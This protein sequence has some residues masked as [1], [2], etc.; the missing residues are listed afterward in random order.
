MQRILNIP[1]EGR[2]KI[3]EQCRAYSDFLQTI[4]IW[5]ERKDRCEREKEE[6]EKKKEDKLNA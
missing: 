6:I 2:D 4:K 3:I 5:I 1:P